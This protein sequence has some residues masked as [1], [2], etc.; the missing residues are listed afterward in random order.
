MNTVP[1]KLKHRILWIR[2][3]EN[4]SG[5]L[6]LVLPL[7]L[8]ASQALELAGSTSDSGNTS[9]VASEWWVCFFTCLSDVLAIGSVCCLILGAIAVL[10]NFWWF[11][12][13]KKLKS[14]TGAQLIEVPLKI[15]F[16]LWCLGPHLCRYS[17]YRLVLKVAEL[18]GPILTPDKHEQVFEM[19]SSGNLAPREGLDSAEASNIFIG[20]WMKGTN[21]IIDRT[22][23]W[24]IPSNPKAF[25]LQKQNHKSS[26]DQEI[27]DVE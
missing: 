4:C 26:S 19:I 20:Y 1:K 10:Y 5:A 18:Q 13:L 22:A 17:R 16:P 23:T 2:V 25:Y 14:A 8:A 24:Y 12:K 21:R 6:Y 11:S 7:L 15:P 3:A 27:S 9:H